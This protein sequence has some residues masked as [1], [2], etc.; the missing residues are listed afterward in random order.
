MQEQ[1]DIFS[2]E[3]EPIQEQPKVRIYD[4]VKVRPATETDDV[5]TYYYLQDYEG[6]TGQIVK[7]TSK[8]LNQYE[9]EFKGVSRNGIF[10][11][12]EIIHVI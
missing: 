11:A 2:T 3:P 7:R 9:V 8:R 10:N 12:D 6:R 5:E 1:L 4:K